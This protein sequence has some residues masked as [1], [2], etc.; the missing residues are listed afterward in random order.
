M[1]TLRTD[2]LILRQWHDEDLAPFATLNA[3]PEVMRHFPSTLTKE[4]SDALAERARHHL[5][6]EGWGL[7]AVAVHDGA[8]FIGFVGLARPSFEAAFTPC[9]EVGWRIAR[10]HWGLGYAPEAAQ[11]ALRV[12][13]RDLGLDE[14]HSWT[15]AANAP[16]LRVMEKIGMHHD[17]ADDFDHPALAEGHPMRRHVRYRLSAAE[18]RP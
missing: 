8:S 2:R 1:T 6:Q 10:E 12:G 18:W 15:V 11:A 9:V 14:I 4:Q 17:E 7:W 5:Q 13:F 16:S 3:D